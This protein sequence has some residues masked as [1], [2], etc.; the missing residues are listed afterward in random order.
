MV[1]GEVEP[2][3]GDCRVVIPMS[4]RSV[5]STVHLVYV[6]GGLLSDLVFAAAA[7]VDSVTPPLCVYI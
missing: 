2:V 1:G 6:L 4:G 7:N 3:V 5:C